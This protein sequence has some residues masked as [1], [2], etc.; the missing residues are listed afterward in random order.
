MKNEKL[1][2]ELF[3]GKV[4]DEL[5]IEKTTKLLR[6]AREVIETANPVNIGVGDISKSVC[7]L[8]DGKGRR[9]FKNCTPPIDEICPVC[10]GLG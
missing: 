2:H 3:I 8:C 5:G 10:K 1:I 9:I 6:E 4:A 7:P